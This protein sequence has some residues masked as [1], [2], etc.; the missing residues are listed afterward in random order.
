MVRGKFVVVNG[1][2][3]LI[4]EASLCREID[5]TRE[6]MERDLVDV[7]RNAAALKGTYAAVL[8]RVEQEPLNLDARS[9]RPFVM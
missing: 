1:K 2:S 5:K 4:D 9:L 6:A 7:Q 3:V 8:D